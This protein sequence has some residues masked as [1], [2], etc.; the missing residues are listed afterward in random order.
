MLSQLS[1]KERYLADILELNEYR[2]SDP[3]KIYFPFA[4]ANGADSIMDVYHN[5][6][7]GKEHLPG[8]T[9]RFPLIWND[10]YLQLDDELS[11]N[12]YRAKTLK[13]S[14]YL[15]CKSFKVD[16]YKRYCRIYEKDCLK[17]GLQENIW[18]NPDAVRLFGPPAETGDFFGV[19]SPGWMFNALQEMAADVY[20]YTHKLKLVRISIYDT[21]MTN[22]HLQQ[23]GKL[24][25]SRQNKHQ[26][27][28]F[29]YLSGRLKTATGS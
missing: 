2:L 7:G 12:R 23:I 19:G 6:F 3:Q 28:L 9:L 17:K 10:H 16:N 14:I 25:E 29:K 24:F 5:E 26:D 20:A 22:G 15:Y 21:I 11:F 27:A 1:F 18:S 8:L 13:S 4:E